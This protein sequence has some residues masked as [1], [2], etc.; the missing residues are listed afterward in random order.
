MLLPCF[1]PAQAMILKYHKSSAECAPF[2]ARDVE[3]LIG[4]G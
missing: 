1:A 3:E 2:S 4:L